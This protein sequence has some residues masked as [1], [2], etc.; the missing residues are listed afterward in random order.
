MGLAAT[1]LMSISLG[2][3]IKVAIQELGKNWIGVRGD[4]GLGIG[5][6]VVGT[7]LSSGVSFAISL[8]LATDGFLDLLGK[9]KQ[10]QHICDHEN[11]AGSGAIN[12][13][14]KVVSGQYNKNFQHFIYGM[15]QERSV[16]MLEYNMFRVPNAMTIEELAFPKGKEPNL[17]DINEDVGVGEWYQF[18]IFSTDGYVSNYVSGLVAFDSC[19][20]DATIRTQYT[21][22]G[23]TF[24]IGCPIPSYLCIYTDG[25]D[26]LFSSGFTALK[27]VDSQVYPQKRLLT[28]GSKME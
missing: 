14:E 3:F 28:I 1:F 18:T 5:V 24:T 9:N 2:K 17:D 25:I 23:W 4:L 26:T 20:I 21:G 16:F 27:L 13:E 8:F 7:Y 11:F 6:A 10:V 12:C 15:G 19:F 22:T